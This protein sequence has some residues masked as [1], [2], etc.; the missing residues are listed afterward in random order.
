MGKAT[1]NGFIEKIYSFAMNYFIPIMLKTY[2]NQAV[3]PRDSAR[4]H[5]ILFEPILK[6]DNSMIESAIENSNDIWQYLSGN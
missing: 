1:H 3:V 5:E 6:R 2:E 4:A